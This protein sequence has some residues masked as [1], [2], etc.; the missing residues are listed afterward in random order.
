[1]IGAGWAGLAA[2]VEATRCGHHVTLYD[3]A[4]QAG[5][6]ARSQAPEASGTRLDNGQH[7]LI[8]AYT[9]TLALMRQVGAD[10]DTL[11]RRLPLQLV[12][13]DGRGLNLPPG[14]AL[15]AFGRGVWAQPDWRIS[16][17]L[18]LLAT[19]GQWAL[20][21]FRCPDHLTVA[22]LTARLPATIRRELIE[23]LC[24]AAL[25]TPADAASARVFLRVLHDA[26]FAGP[27]AADL[28]LPRVPLAELLPEPALDWLQVRGATLKLRQRVERLDCVSADPARPCWRVD[29]TLHDA[30]ILACS[31]TEAARLTAPHA[32]PWAELAAAFRYEPIIT[33]TLSCPGARLAAPMVR[34]TDGADAPAQFAFDQR[35]IQQA[36]DR[37]TFVVSGAAAWLQ[38]GDAVTQAVRRQAESALRPIRPDRPCGPPELVRTITEKRATFRCTPGLPRPPA[39]ITRGL[40]GAGDYISGPYP[41]TLEGAVRSGRDAVRLLT[42]P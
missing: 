31:A 5:G 35:Q 1:M 38:R 20:R 42:Q 18:K 3:M 10:P 2:A 37:F 12:D 32:A 8:G 7:I 25:N 22:E 39:R 21:G 40:V 36:G 41:A 30:V 16:E 13:A 33:V 15:L 6:R 17:R 4:P 23:P 34:L 19:A 14:P 29:D 9:E 24:V 11:L 28:L 27:G 26:L